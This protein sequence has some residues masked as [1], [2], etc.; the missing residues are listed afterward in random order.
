MMEPSFPE[1]A[2]MPWQVHRYLVGKTSAEIW[3]SRSVFTLAREVYA[4]H[5]TK[6][7][8]FGPEFSLLAQ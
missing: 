8:V 6:V 4:E 1:A 7:D 5:T 2:D 3:I